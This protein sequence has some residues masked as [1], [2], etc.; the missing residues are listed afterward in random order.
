MI[1]IYSTHIKR[2][3]DSVLS[4]A[5]MLAF[6]WL[7]VLILV[8]YVIT[9]QFP[10]FFLQQRI[11]K[12]QK[13]FQLIKFRTLSTNA[14][15]DLQQRRFWLGDVLR[16]LSLDELPQ[17]WNVLRGEM[18]LVG[19]RPLPMDYL[20]LM[21]E[22]QKSRHVLRPGITGWTQVNGRHGIT[23]EQK[24]KLDLEY[25]HNVSFWLDIKILFRTF[26]LFINPVKDKSL[27]E[28]KFEGSA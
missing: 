10:I 13:P 11:G 14:E 26:M 20:P 17:L 15:A 2:I 18:A 12:N 9:F 23:W 1:D 22:Q 25:V 24:F 27:H 8:V 7:F 21:N 3:L 6:S 28:K 19:P 4:F 16:Y 5:L